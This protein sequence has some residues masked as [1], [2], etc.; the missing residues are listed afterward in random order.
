MQ[1]YTIHQNDTTYPARLKPLQRAPDTLY[2]RGTLPSADALCLAVV[3]TR[4]ASLYG[5]S[6]TQR[7]AGATAR[8]GV[9]IISGMALGIDAVAHTAALEANTPTVAVLGG[10]VDDESIYPRT[11][12]MLAHEILKNGGALVSEQPP[13]TQP[14]GYH[15]PERNRIIAGLAH[16]VLVTEG[17]IKSGSLITAKIALEYGRDV[18]ACPHNIFTTRGEGPNYLIQHGAY[19]IWGADNL[20]EAL[21]LTPQTT[22]QHHT[23][24]A[25]KI[26]DICHKEPCTLDDLACALSCAP[27]EL[28][29]AISTLELQGV[30][31]ILNGTIQLQDV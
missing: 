28:S 25:Q 17:T 12:L 5:R 9:I 3:G 18:F 15:F 10:G 11:N 8:A 1:L 26:L 7:L 20:L 22:R 24:L 30:V 27:S 6:I 21:H 14:F 29:V 4:K 31:R 23:G 16:A 13:G 2:I 19:P